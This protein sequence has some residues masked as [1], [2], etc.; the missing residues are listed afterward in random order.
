MVPLLLVRVGFRFHCVTAL[1][2]GFVGITFRQ[3]PVAP[4]LR[5]IGSCESFLLSLENI[6]DWSCGTIETVRGLVYWTVHT[7]G[8][9]YT[10]LW[11]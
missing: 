1:M 3:A 6:W 10:S 8:L 9:N 7:I 5:L 11:L 4:D 2:G